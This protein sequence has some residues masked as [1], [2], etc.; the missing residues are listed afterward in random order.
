MNGTGIIIW[1]LLEMRT[2]TFVH[3]KNPHHIIP[4]TEHHKKIS[5]E[6]RKTIPTFPA[7]HSGFG[8]VGFKDPIPYTQVPQTLYQAGC[9]RG[10][11]A[12]SKVSGH[13]TTRYRPETVE[14][15]AN[16]P[17][18][19][20]ANHSRMSLLTVFNIYCSNRLHRF[21]K[22]TPTDHQICKR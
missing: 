4:E 8:Y 19:A 9:R 15:V 1:T 12:D 22:Y 14:R 6:R 17:I 3:R 20:K 16:V 5:R 21:T 10:M 7:H 11:G 2:L 13:Y 18:R